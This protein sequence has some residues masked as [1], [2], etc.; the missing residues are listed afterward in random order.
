[1]RKALT[2]LCVLQ[3]FIAF[4]CTMGFAVLVPRCLSQRCRGAVGAWDADIDRVPM[5]M[6]DSAQ[7]DARA[8]QYCTRMVVVYAPCGA[9]EPLL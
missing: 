5:C 9:F 3:C 4:R 1:M 6:H 7:L 2:L 8:V